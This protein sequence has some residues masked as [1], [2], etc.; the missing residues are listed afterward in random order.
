MYKNKDINFLTKIFDFFT[1]DVFVID[2]EGNVKYQNKSALKNFSKVKNLKKIAHQ[3]DFEICLLNSD[4]IL[5]YTP[6]NVAISAKENFQA[7]VTRQIK[8]NFFEE[9][10][11]SA[12]IIDENL[13]LIIISNS[14]QNNFERI[15]FLEQR[16]RELESKITDSGELKSKLESIIVRTNLINLI[17]DKVSEFI[18][19][20]KILKIIFEQIKKTIDINNIEFEKTPDNTKKIKCLTDE[21]NNISKLSVPVFRENKIF[22]AIIL[23]KKNRGNSWSNEEI[24]LIKNITSLLATAF[25][26][27][28]L[29]EELKKQ[30]IELEDALKQLKNAQLQIVQSEKL[31]TLGQLVAGVAH[32]IN[33]P[34]GAISSNLDLLDKISLN[35]KL[36]IET[37]IQEIMPVNKDAIRRIERLV[38][39]LKN[40]TRL[41]EAKKKKVDIK[42]GILSSIDLISY[43]LKNKVNIKTDFSKLP[44][45]NCSPDYIN[46]VFM[47][48]LLN[49]CQSIQQNGEIFIKT[50]Q[51]ENYALITISDNGC[52]IEKKYLDKIFDFGFTTKKIGQGTGLGL[53]LA[54]KIIDEHRGKIEVDSILNEGTTFKIYLPL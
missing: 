49:A 5:L 24:D 27:E 48:I 15:A 9:Y 46:Q 1:D 37:V 19:T 33:T 30:K 52:G 53:A 50:K 47:N 21:E 26:K 13:K 51:F 36:D 11:L 7:N 10:A 17:A 23:S 3:F 29:Y 28:E 16:N 34:L 39:S 32:E 41:D 43:E 14:I 22:G 42:E 4:D 35:K 45:V 25:S 12:L 20:Q 18:D 2:I 40:F 31:A 38:K 54:K 8:N 44:L 6:L